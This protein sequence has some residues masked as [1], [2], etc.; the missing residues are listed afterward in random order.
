MGRFVTGSLTIKTM[1]ALPVP[2]LSVEEYLALDRAAE[3]PS[4]YH[5]GEMF[6]VTAVT[7]EHIQIGISLSGMLKVALRGKPCKVSGT[8]LKVRVSPSK[9]LLPDLVVVRGEP[10]FTDP[11]RD[12]VTNP[13]VVI[14][15]LSPSTADYDYGEKFILY[16]RLPSFEEYLLVSQDQAR[17]EVY[18]KTADGGWLLSTY[19]G[20]ETVVPIESVGVDLPLA[21][22]YSEVEFP[23]SAEE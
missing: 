13:R 17:V 6:P 19:L 18:R 20:R 23:P 10:A 16:R 8:L 1:A 7:W 9:F 12:T 3:V 15:I 2:R 11:R 14:E 22:V 21:E 4:E 5:D